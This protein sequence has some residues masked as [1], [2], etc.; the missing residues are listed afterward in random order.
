MRINPTFDAAN[1]IV[2]Y[3][4]IPR[5]RFYTCIQVA[6]LA[7]MFT[8]LAKAA[9]IAFGLAWLGFFIAYLRDPQYV[10]LLWRSL[11]RSPILSPLRAK[12]ADWKRIHHA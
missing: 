4:W 5:D 6:A 10:T 2:T 9:G 12:S 3:A 11:K 7:F 8:G 1:K